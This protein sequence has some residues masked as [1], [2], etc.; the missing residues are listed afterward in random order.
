LCVPVGCSVDVEGVVAVAGCPDGDGVV[1][2]ELEW[3]RAL[4]SGS[5]EWRVD[6]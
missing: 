2:V 6:G 3:V 1:T 5:F 4:F